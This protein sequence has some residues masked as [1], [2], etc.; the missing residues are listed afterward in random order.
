MNRHDSSPVRRAFFVAI[1]VVAKRRDY[2][3]E[4]PWI[5]I[6]PVLVVNQLHYAVLAP[7]QSVLEKIAKRNHRETARVDLAMPMAEVESFLPAL[8]PLICAAFGMTNNA[9]GRVYVIEPEGGGKG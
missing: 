7:E 1:I 5:G 2:R 4:A 3:C 6:G 8:R 9:E